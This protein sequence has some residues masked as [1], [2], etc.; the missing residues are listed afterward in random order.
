MAK[1]GSFNIEMYLKFNLGPLHLL[2]NFVK[3][4]LASD[5]T[6]SYLK[7][8]QAKIRR[9]VTTDLNKSTAMETI[10]KR[11]EKKSRFPNKLFCY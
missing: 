3:E 7:K 2:D 6:K 9:L 8:E 1:I 5:S 4:I 11:I 10:E